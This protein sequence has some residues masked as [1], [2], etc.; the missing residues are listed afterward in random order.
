MVVP[1]YFPVTPFPSL[2]EY[3]L[4]DYYDL[5]PGPSE[6]VN[7]SRTRSEWFDVSPKL[8]K[9]MEKLFVPKKQ[10]LHFRHV[11][12]R[13]ESENRLL[14]VTSLSGNRR[15]EVIYRTKMYPFW[16]ADERKDNYEENLMK[17]EQR[18]DAAGQTEESDFD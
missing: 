18:L 1:N 7:T 6:G 12:T 16:K 10:M 9:E 8:A 13:K 15:F 17:E 14:D 11:G 3:D 4:N 2:S 5:R